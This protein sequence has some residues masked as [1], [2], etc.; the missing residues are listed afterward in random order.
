MTARYQYGN[1]TIRK[2]KKGPD[3]WQF[4]WMENGK[5]K[6]VLIGTVE[7]YLT[8]ADAERAVKHLRITINTKNPQQSFHTVIV[9]T[10]IDRFMEEYVPKRCRENTRNNYRGLYN[11]HIRPR[12]EAEF[13][14]NVKTTAVEDWLETY[15]HSR[16]VKSHVRNLMHTL[17]Q[18]AIRWDVVERNPIDLVRQSGKRLKKPRVLTPAEFRALLE[19]LQEPYKTMVMTIACF[20]FPN[21]SLFSGEIWISKILQSR[22]SVVLSAE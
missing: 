12:W 8:Q 3:V 6:S 20:G 21:W 7:K 1:L 10:L 14:E 22:S 4:R 18:A 16:Q 11:H 5:P 15:P 13:V 17:F 19:M 2:R 9:G